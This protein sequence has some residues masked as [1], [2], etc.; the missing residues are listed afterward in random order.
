MMAGAALT[1][2][3]CFRNA[4]VSLCSGFALLNIFGC[5]SELSTLPL[6]FPMPT[7]DPGLDK[8]AVET[9]GLPTFDVEIEPP[10]S[11]CIHGGLR[12]LSSGQVQDNSKPATESLP[13]LESVVCGNELLQWHQTRICA[14]PGE[15]HCIVSGTLVAGQVEV[16]SDLSPANNSPSP[17]PSPTAEAE[18]SQSPKPAPALP[19]CSENGQVDCI[20]NSSFRAADLANLAPGNIRLGTSIAG[21]AGHY[22]SQMSPLQG[23]FG[24]DLP[25][26]SSSVTAGHYQCFKSDGSRIFGTIVNPGLIEPGTAD[27]LF[28]SALYT[29]FTVKGDSGLVSSNILSGSSVFGVNGGVTLPLESDVRSGISYGPATSL[30]GGAIASCLSAGSVGCITNSTL[31]PYLQC[32][33]DGQVDCVA[34]AT[35]QA[36]REQL[37]I[38][39]SDS[40]YDEGESVQFAISTKNFAEGSQ[41]YYSIGG[42]GISAQDLQSGTMSG[43]VSVTANSAQVNLTLKED[44]SIEGVENLSLARSSSGAVPVSGLRLGRDRDYTP[45][46]WLG[47]VAEVIAFSSSL[48]S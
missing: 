23:S 29:G 35:F 17:I 15:S 10:G 43:Q 28:Q 18:V 12:I 5:S 9:S 46:G 21:V 19:R 30:L 22:P 2:K 14:N 38:V 26:I 42:A 13:K 31:K 39:T 37:V 45:R 25:S 6:S 3:I 8:P 11:R 48:S 16:K 33:A 34:N 27:Q 47:K 40:N 4:C 36:Q 7:R 44:N 24:D 20:A 41:L 32:S 1:P